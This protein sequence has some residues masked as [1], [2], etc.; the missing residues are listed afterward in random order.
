M[1]VIFFIKYRLRLEIFAQSLITQTPKLHNMALKMPNTSESP[2]AYDFNS[3]THLE[4]VLQNT[5]E[6]PL[7][8]IS[9]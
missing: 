5:S 8:M 2:L 1:K 7:A 3:K 6:L 9:P 4:N